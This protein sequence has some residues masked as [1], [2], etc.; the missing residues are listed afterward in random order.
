MTDDLALLEDYIQR[1]SNW[2]RWGAEDHLGTVNL[3]TPEKVR[4]AARLVRTGKTISL[5]MPYDE[6]GPQ[7]GNLGRHN[8]HLYQ[9]A[10][11]PGYLTGE[12]QSVETP[13]MTKW[14]E[15]SGQPANAL[16]DDV[17]VMPT[18]SGTQWD[19]LCHIFWRGQMYNGYSAADAGTG[20]SRTNGVQH[21]TGKIITRGVFVDVAE[22]R[23]VDSLEPGDAITVDELEKCLAAKKLEIRTGDALIVR[24]GFMA[25]RRG[26][27]QDYAGGPAPGLSLHTAPW[28]RE[29]DIAAVATDT[30]GV[31]V[32][33]NEIDCWQPF[34]VVCLT[35][36][37]L[38]I[39]EIWD[40]D[41]LSEDC[42]ADG[43]YEFM[44]SASPL[45]LTG[46]SGSPVSAVAIK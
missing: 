42:K 44:L 45:P 39:G 12:Q 6:G 38:A 37:G 13:T 2:G 1:C 4:E 23:G 31:E 32:R 27:W 20:G 10:S 25:A 29:H 40:L 14:R 11:G 22:H 28:I 36:T 16:Y 46:A 5:T 8:P 30:W 21:Y 3:I 7:T 41:G 17:L 24:T 33:P 9:L 34:H 26:K 18:Q 15:S 35:H 19:A 43:V